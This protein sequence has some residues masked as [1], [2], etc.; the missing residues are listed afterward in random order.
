MENWND[1][2]I[3]QMGRVPRRKISWLAILSV[4]ILAF[5]AGITVA[6]GV[7]EFG[8]TATVSHLDDDDFADFLSVLNELQN[9]HYFFDENN[10]LIRGAIDGMIAATGDSYTSFFS[11]SDFEGAMS[12]LRE[13]FYGIGAEVTTING[14]ATVVTPMPGSPAESYGVLPG[15]VIMSVDGVDVRD[16]NLRDVINRI[17]GEY[18]TVV[19][20]G[21]LR[22]GSD[23]IYIDV[24]RG[25]ILNE[26]VTTDVFKTN[27][28]TIGFI[29]VT[30]F[31]EAT[32]R[33]FRDAI[34]T[35]DEVGIDGLIV[36]MRNNSG[37]YLNAVNG[38]VS[39]LLPSGL[40]ITSAVDRNGR[41]TV[42]ST[43]G[44]SSAR[45]DVDIVTLING[46]SASAAEIFAAAMMESGGFEVIGTTSFGKGT[47]QQSR[48]IRNDSMLQM[49]IQV[50]KTP[51]GHLIE[52]YGVEP[53][54]Y[55]EAS[56]F[57][58]ILQVSLGDEDLLEYD[59]VH[60]GV[61]NAQLT[62]DALGYDVNRT[63]G[64]F[65]LSTVHAL[66]VFQA[67]NDLEVTGTIDSITASTLSMLLR[68][69]ARNPEY[70]AQIQAAI[71]W[72]DR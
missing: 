34:G 28:M 7:F 29:R 15:D 6:Y 27:G 17:R 32:L 10:D 19:R 70:D 31:G 59:M 43:R 42:H 48:P 63:D 13:S 5:T 24:T 46:G 49:T 14:A 44:D 21:I 9:N 16:E 41:E 36:D 58:R 1:N 51:D 68:N 55:V 12:H 50:W 33:D 20:L 40:P 4:A 64:Y 35:L 39:Y 30:T 25:R 23:L 67:D 8:Q 22:S 37:G 18:G 56:E 47:V 72:F 65:D 60:S 57:L 38:M 26:T 53:T 11:L 69:K 62:L 52:G 61:M 3:E 54:I 2:G 71:E 45:L 66:Q